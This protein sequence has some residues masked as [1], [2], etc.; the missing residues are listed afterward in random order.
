MDALK[1]MLELWE[2]YAESMNKALIKLLIF[3]F[4]IVNVFL[5]LL[6]DDNEDELRTATS[7]SEC[8][9]KKDGIKICNRVQR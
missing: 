7:P 8:V 9:H 2:K 4:V 3:V 5:S 1:Q 6:S